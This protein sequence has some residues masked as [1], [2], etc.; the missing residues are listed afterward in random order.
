MCISDNATAVTCSTAGI[1]APNPDPLMTIPF[2]RS[3]TTSVLSPPLIIFSMAL[4]GAAILLNLLLTHP[5]IFNWIHARNLHFIC[6][7]FAG[8]TAFFL[9]VT[10]LMTTS[11]ISGGISALSTISLEVLTAQRGVLLEAMLWSAFGIWSIAFLYS[12]WVRWWEILERREFSRGGLIRGLPS[13]NNK[14]QANISMQ[15]VIGNQIE[16]P[17]TAQTEPPVVQ[18]LESPLLSEESQESSR[19]PSM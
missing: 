18:M 1:E 8:A 19:V 7:V 4:S 6:I 11:A 2:A 14:N 13:I 9:F 10:A 3:L 12:W 17:V 16:E 5:N 15:N